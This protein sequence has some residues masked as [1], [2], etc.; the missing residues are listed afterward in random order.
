MRKMTH[1]DIG[2]QREWLVIE[3]SA[4]RSV[5]ASDEMRLNPVMGYIPRDVVE[6]EL[7]IEIEDGR[8]KWFRSEDGERMRAHPEW[9]TNENDF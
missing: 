4:S 9:R 6:D 8:C 5:F 1:R 3:H 2:T 7:G